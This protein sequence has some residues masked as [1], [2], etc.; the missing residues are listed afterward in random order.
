MGNQSAA[1]RAM[2]GM[3]VREA[4]SLP[5]A[6]D[7]PTANRALGLSRTAGYHMA[8]SGTYP[9]EIL[10]VGRYLRVRRSDLLAFLAIQDTS[11]SPKDN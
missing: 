3:S 5:I 1:K 2:P 10:A 8:R 6:V 11:T 9:V 7:L 4:I